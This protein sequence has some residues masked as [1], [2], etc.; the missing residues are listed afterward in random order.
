MDFFWTDVHHNIT[1]ALYERSHRPPQLPTTTHEAIASGQAQQGNAPLDDAVISK[2]AKHSLNRSK[3]SEAAQRVLMRQGYARSSL[4]DIA[5]EAGV[6]LGR[7]HYY[8]TD[9]MHLMVSVLRDHQTRFIHSIHEVAA[10]AGTPGERCQRMA[11]RWAREMR[12][13]GEAYRNWYDLR[14][15]ALFDRELRPIV[16]EMEQLQVSAVAALVGAQETNAKLIGQIRS[17]Y[18]PMLGGIFH[19]AIQRTTFGEDLDFDQLEQS[20]VSVLLKI[21]DEAEAEH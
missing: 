7:L 14:N 5:V 9:K 20:L 21:L 1:H 18:V 17:Q 2:Q 6:S 15:Q 8:F 19:Y 13:S 10:S 16:S 3:L 11:A 4:R 12:E